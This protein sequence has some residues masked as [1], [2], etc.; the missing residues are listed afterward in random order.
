MS[1]QYI[2]TLIES[3][4]DFGT[5]RKQAPVP[6]PLTLEPDRKPRG[7][8]AAR[9]RRRHGNLAA[10]LAALCSA[11]RAAALASPWIRPNVKE[12][13]GAISP[14]TLR[15]Y[16]LTRDVAAG[17]WSAQVVSQTA[18]SAEEGTELRLVPKNVSAHFVHSFEVEIPLDAPGLG[19]ELLEVEGG[20]DDDLG[21]TVAT[22]LV[23]GGNAARAIATTDDA[24]DI[25]YG[26]IIAAAEL[27]LD[28]EGGDTEIATANTEC[29]GSDATVAALATLLER[30]DDRDSVRSAAMVLT[31]KRLLRRP[32]L[33]V[34]VQYPPEQ[35]LP[36]ET[37]RLQPGDNLRLSLLQRG[38]KLNDPLAQRYDGKQAGGNCGG[39]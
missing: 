24:P 15:E 19:V 38:I 25:M 6:S 35:G 30:R 31:L 16:R 33:R 36:P 7:M 8:T 13:L 39:E 4:C 21:I 20:R 10:C 22:G 29:L 17:G 23:P 26:D 1:Q 32:D 28:K 18:K 11:R 3:S 27:V 37:L 2:P 5:S 9:H 14:E 34:K 12:L